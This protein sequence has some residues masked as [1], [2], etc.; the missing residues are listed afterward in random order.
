[1][2]SAINIILRATDQA[3]G[4]VRSVG[5]ALK[6]AFS[7]VKS[8]SMAGIGQGL[9][10]LSAAFTA[11]SGV[12]SQVS[13]AFS[14]FFSRLAA[15]A[16]EYAKLERATLRLGRAM[17]SLGA[18]R[19]E[20]GELLDSNLGVEFDDTDVVRANLLLRQLTGNLRGGSKDMELLGDIAA[21]TDQ[22]LSS[23]AQSVG[24]LTARIA[25]GGTE[26]S[27]YT[28]ALVA[29]RVLTAEDAA[30][31]SRMAKASDDAGRKIQFLFDALNRQHGGAL[32]ETTADINQASRA[33]KDFIGDTWRALGRDLWQPLRDIGLFLS[34]LVIK[35]L[36]FAVSTIVNTVRFAADFLAAKSND[37][38]IKDAAKFALDNNPYFG[39]GEEGNPVVPKKIGVPPDENN[40]PDG[41]GGS[42][43]PSGS[44]SGRSAGAK[45]TSLADLK[46]D[47]AAASERL[48]QAQAK[49][50]DEKYRL[51]QEVAERQATTLQDRLAW[52]RRT[53]AQEE[54]ILATETALF[55]AQ[56]DLAEIVAKRAKAAKD[57]AKAIADAS[58]NAADAQYDSLESE[59]EDAA[60]KQKTADDDRLAA[61]RAEYDLTWSRATP[62]QRKKRLEDELRALQNIQAVGITNAQI[63]GER[64]E[65]KDQIRGAIAERQQR[66]DAVN[67]EIAAAKPAS[68][69]PPPAIP[70]PRQSASTADLLSAMSD[71]APVRPTPGFWLAG[72]APL[73]KG[74]IHTLTRPG[75]HAAVAA[76]PVKRDPVE[77]YTKRTADTL[78]RIEK[79]LQPP[80]R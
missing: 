43:A 5:Q 31:L 59:R 51:Q 10:G 23:V 44:A 35:P 18:A 14:A 66:L 20:V 58:K 46:L 30:E 68:L 21:N 11:V 78:D 3:S 39:Q 25:A 55:A 56:A 64:L 71:T 8:G 24:L 49:T 74:N 29:A 4:I 65:N 63:N 12:I 69:T 41:E 1:M 53:G 77:D 72:I 19:R 38:S 27:R 6:N 61:D 42:D 37:M 33:M 67:K 60:R 50:E 80:R 22:D 13:S 26:L 57:A 62:A 70:R 48:L 40:G 45:S 47:T 54:V 15:G 75:A 16:E 73:M 36:Q 28:M 79:T 9:L 17:G 34:A 7:G 52:Q 32:K 2:S 76:A